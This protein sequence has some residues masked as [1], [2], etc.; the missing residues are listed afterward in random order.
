M[1]RLGLFQNVYLRVVMVIAVT[2]V[3]MLA[4]SH[5]NLSRALITSRQL[6]LQQ[7][8]EWFARHAAETSDYDQIAEAWRS[9]HDGVRLQIF[10]SNGEVLADSFAHHPVPEQNG[11]ISISA[12]APILLNERG[13]IIVLSRSG[14]RLFPDSMQFGL[15]ITAILLLLLAAGLLFPLTRRL[16][17]T[18]TQLSGL[19][20][21]VAGGEF[22]QTLPVRGDRDLGALITAFNTMSVRLSE[23]EQRNR[24]L[25]IDV[26]HEFRSP[27]GRITA[28]VDT[29]KR[30]PEELEDHVPPIREELALLD[31]LTGDALAAARFSGQPIALNL[32]PISMHLWAKKV[33]SRLAEPMRSEG[34]SVAC[35]IA[36]SKGVT[37]IDPDRIMQALGNLMDNAKKAVSGLAEPRILLETRK[38]GTDMVIR[39]SDNGAGVSETDRPFVFDRFFQADPDSPGSGLGLSVSMELIQAHKG[40]LHLF[41]ISS[42]GTV[43]EI[44]L[45]I[46]AA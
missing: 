31:R 21:R 23:A 12:E 14:M 40:Q 46:S 25:L 26:S 16:V 24:Q 2:L 45:P 18:F 41:P 42:G 27:L 37:M 4:F 34:I 39:V 36:D 6:D 28:L 30:H 35:Q 20:E 19:A 3:A 10:S 43:A 29:M 17:N 15:I 1:I 32:Q 44:S 8:A 5:A 11:G 9:M 38:I 7:E 22:G 33:F 13:D